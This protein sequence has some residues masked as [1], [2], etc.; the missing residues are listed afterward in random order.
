LFRIAS[1]PGWES[2]TDGRFESVQGDVGQ[3]RRQHSSYKVANFF[4]YRCKSRSE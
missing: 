1:R 4:F 3:Q 2:G